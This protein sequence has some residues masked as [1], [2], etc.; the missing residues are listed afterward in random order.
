MREGGGRTSGCSLFVCLFVG[1]KPEKLY[2]ASFFFFGLESTRLACRVLPKHTQ[3]EVQYWGNPEV[4]RL[5]GTP[6][7]LV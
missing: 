4:A 3:V 1:I 6:A 2:T 7:I 5:E